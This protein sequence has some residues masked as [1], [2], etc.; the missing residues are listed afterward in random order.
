MTAAR[1]PVRSK[2][3]EQGQEQK[4]GLPGLDHALQILG[5]GFI[6]EAAGE[7]RIGQ[8]QRIFSGVLAVLL[9]EAVAIRDIRILDAVQHHVHGADAQ[10]GRIE[11]EAVEEILVK[12]LAQLV[13]AE[14]R[15]MMLAQVFIDGD[16][17]AAS[18]ASRIADHVL[19][20]RRHQLD[21]QSR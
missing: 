5:G 6:V 1:P 19:G 8:Y 21:H 12:M 9:G 10:H 11:V 4:L 14:Q 3:Q 18:A 2:P 20:L 16:Q 7:R 15:L 13:V 17:K